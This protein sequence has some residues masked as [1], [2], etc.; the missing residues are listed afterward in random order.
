M[1]KSQRRMK[2]RDAPHPETVGVAGDAFVR[3]SRFIKFG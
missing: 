1:Q 3:Y 2:S